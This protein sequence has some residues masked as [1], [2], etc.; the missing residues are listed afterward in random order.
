MYQLVEE[1]ENEVPFTVFDHEPVPG[2]LAYPSTGRLMIEEVPE[3]NERAI[4][5]FNSKSD[6]A[7]PLSC[8]PSNFSVSIDLGL[9][10]V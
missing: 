3:N 8:N 5:L 6:D 9:C 10:R 1:Y 4:V 7:S 2:E